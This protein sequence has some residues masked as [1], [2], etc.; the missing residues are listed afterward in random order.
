MGE[1][2]K[3]EPEGTEPETEGEAP[4]EDADSEVPKLEKGMTP[5]QR[6]AAK[7][8]AKATKKKHFKEELKEQARES[9]EKAL[10]NAQLASA[11]AEPAL[12][13]EVQQVARDFSDFAHDNRKG[14]LGAIFA[15][16]AISVIAILAHRTMS[17]SA[18][19]AASTLGSA[20]ETA[21]AAIDAEDKDGKT[22]DGKPVFASRADRSKKAIEAYGQVAKKFGDDAVAPWAKLGE[23]AEHVAAGNYD[24]AATL[25]A[26]VYA[27]QKAK[28][29]LAGRALEGQ[30][31]ALEAAGKKD[32]AL[33]RFEE[34]A[35]LPGGAFKDSAEY[36][37]AR[38]KLDKGDTEGG[39]A[40]LK[41]LYDRLSD[42]AEG[43]PPSR[44]LR[45]E[46]E[47]RLAEL[48]SSLVDKGTTGVDNQQFS[49]EQLQRLLEQLK[50][51]GG[52]PGGAGDGE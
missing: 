41:A 52:V 36:H 1:E 47:Q 31:I 12:P 10:A 25:Y 7:K 17:S 18:A 5:G 50:L 24:Q 8:A 16:V 35:K 20:L 33:T 2:E 45:G 9:E 22:D 30:A 46:V 51:Q 4:P 3:L 40:M 34:L 48:D 32:E 13:D 19:E 14:I 26:A 15:F 39:K 38:L 6:L 49:Q 43:A 21:N 44:Y 11:P 42:P 27:A 23:A 28:P 37:I 29:S